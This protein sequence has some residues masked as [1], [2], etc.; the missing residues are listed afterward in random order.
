ALGA[1]LEV[2]GAKQ[3]GRQQ[4]LILLWP[5][6][7]RPDPWI[8]SSHPMHVRD[9]PA[10]SRLRR[11]PPL[12]CGC[13]TTVDHPIILQER[14]VLLHRDLC[15]AWTP[16]EMEDRL[17]LGK[18][19]HERNDL[20]RAGGL[21]SPGQQQLIVLARVVLE[22]EFPIHVESS[23]EGDERRRIVAQLVQGHTYVELHDDHRLVV[24]CIAVEPNGTTRGCDGRKQVVPT[25]RSAAAFGT[26]E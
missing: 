15:I 26:R 7:S 10:T 9:G 16:G 23:L 11:D 6:V 14:T 20:R 5:R 13:R 3:G 8:V 4:P 18:V 2:R 12:E 25:I 19:L 22:A 1:H 21:A 17:A 24:E